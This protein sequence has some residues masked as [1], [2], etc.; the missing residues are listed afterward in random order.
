MQIFKICFWPYLKKYIEKKDV[1]SNGNSKKNRT[2]IRI[3]KILSVEVG[4]L[5][6]KL[7]YMYSHPY[8]YN[9]KKSS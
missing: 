7:K 4:Q 8:N 2:D 5:N 3:R 9:N 1:I 6:R